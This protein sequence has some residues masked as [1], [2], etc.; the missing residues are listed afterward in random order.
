MKIAAFR[1][2]EK[3][4]HTSELGLVESWVSLKTHPHSNA[5]HTQ[6]LFRFR[7]HRPNDVSPRQDTN[8]ALVFI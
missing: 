4:P 3:T 2:Y 5:L 7:C 1:L 8:N 6:K